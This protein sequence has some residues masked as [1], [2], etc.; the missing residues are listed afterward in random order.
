MI[1]YAVVSS[2]PSVAITNSELV[3]TDGK[4]IL[5]PHKLI[6]LIICKLN[7]KL[8]LIKLNSRKKQWKPW[9]EESTDGAN[10][11][12]LCEGGLEVAEAAGGEVEES[13]A[14]VSQA[15]EVAPLVPA[16]VRWV[17]R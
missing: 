10:G 6:L 11:V 2:L 15:S 14:L 4:L 1:N 16:F 12:D 7:K 9:K 17:Y 8:V 3:L 5:L 13:I